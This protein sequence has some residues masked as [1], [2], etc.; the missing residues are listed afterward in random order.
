MESKGKPAV[1]ELLENNIFSISAYLKLLNGVLNSFEARIMG[2]V[3][4]IK[5]SSVGH[6][7][8]SLKDKKDQSVLS[9]VIWNYDY[10]LCGVQ[11]KEGL[12][13]IAK[14]IPDVYPPTGRLSFKTKMIQL[15]G[16]G[17][18]KKEYEK[19]KK[20][21]EGEGLF[22]LER[23]KEIPPF[24]QKV[25]IITSKQG[26]V[27]SDF[28]NNLGRFGFKI[29]FVDSRVEG[30]EAV[31]ELLNSVKTVKKLD[32]DVL[33]I[34]RGGGS[35]ESFLAFN[36]EVL[37]REVSEL[38]FPVIAAIG[39]DKDVPLLAL[40][41]DKMVSTPSMAANLLNQS[42]LEAESELKNKEREIINSFSYAL[43]DLEYKTD[44]L[45]LKIKNRLEKVISGFKMIEYRIKTVIPKILEGEMRKIKE[46]IESIE[47]T[48]YHNDPERN[49]KLGY[50]I[51]TN[52]KGIIKKVDDVKVEDIV[53]L[54]VFDGVINTQVKKIQKY[55]RKKS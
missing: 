24:I 48:I 4:E 27:L 31:K 25:G 20:K 12:E 55:E 46:K 34:M 30:L 45:F 19:L 23:K 53:D 49:L 7:Y 14:G 22:S 10:K 51:A 16:E 37:I 43:K 28:L 2:E 9:C 18:L 3:S 40:M 39:H 38:P 52:E 33:V 1:K 41:A 26:A 5:I 35:L 50:C 11:L 32:L 17:E 42:W 29:K 15:V 36:N 54:K 13:I 44:G 21:L 8:F 6:V 47:K